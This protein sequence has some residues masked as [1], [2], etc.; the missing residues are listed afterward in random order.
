MDRG[1]I[2]EF[3]LRYRQIIHGYLVTRHDLSMD[4]KQFLQA[5][6]ES[7]RGMDWV[8]GRGDMPSFTR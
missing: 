1:L 2:F 6:Y 5:S 3:H 7:G 8:A 4:Q